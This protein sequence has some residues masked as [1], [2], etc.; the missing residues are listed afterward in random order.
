MKEKL[1]K[2]GKKLL[3]VLIIF[4]ILFVALIVSYQVRYN[5]KAKINDYTAEKKAESYSEEIQKLK[6]ENEDVALL[7]YGIETLVGDEAKSVNSSIEQVTLLENGNTQAI[8]NNANEKIKELT[9]GEIFYLEGDSS[10]PYQEAFFG[11]VVSNTENDGKTT[12]ITETPKVDEIFDMVDI[13]LSET[14]TED[15]LKNIKPMEGVNITYLGESTGSTVQKLDN[16]QEATV[17]NLTNLQFE[18][19]EIKQ[20]DQKSLSGKLTLEADLSEHLQSL[21]KYLRKSEISEEELKNIY[22]KING[23][24]NFEHVNFDTVFDWDFFGGIHD[25]QFNIDKK[26]T[27]SF[28]FETG[29]ET[30]FGGEE[31]ITKL[32]IA[33]ICGVKEKLIPLFY[34]D[35]GT[36][37]MFTVITNPTNLSGSIEDFKTSMPISLGIMVY[38]DFQGN[39][40]IGLSLDYSY[41]SETINEL[42]I[43]ENDEWKFENKEVYNEEKST[44]N[45]KGEIST[46]GDLNTG[47]DAMVNIGSANIIDLAILKVGVEADFIGSLSAG[48]EWTK[49]D[50]KLTHEEKFEGHARVYLKLLDLDI[51]FKLKNKILPLSI[52]EQLTLLDITLLELGELSPSHYNK[53]I[54][55]TGQVSAEDT[56][57]NYYKTSYGQLIKEDKTDKEKQT[58]YTKEFDQ[59]CAIDDSYIYVTVFSDDGGTDV[60]RIDKEKPLYKTVIENVSYVLTQDNNYIYYVAKDEEKKIYRYNRSNSEIDEF[61]SFD[62]EVQLMIEQDDGNFYITTLDDGLGLGFLGMADNYYYVVGK[63]KNIIHEYGS[64]PTVEQYYISDQGNYYVAQKFY[65]YGR[66]RPTATEN[67]FMS[68]D[69]AIQVPTETS[70]GWKNESF[71]IVTQTQL[72]DYSGYNLNVYGTPNGEMRTITTVKSK[73]AMFTLSESDSGD[74]Y[75]FDQEENDVVLYK[76]DANLTN[77]TEVK[78]FPNET[79]RCQME[80]CSMETTDNVLYFYQIDSNDT[81]VLYRYDMN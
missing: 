30:E 81:K 22:L 58:I 10:T 41:E 23:E 55:K 51:K 78:R 68:K 48:I 18:N 43:V 53:D 12:L 49:D 33:D 31:T 34:M 56:K 20:V 39:V 47:I 80:N 13:D 7:S 44:L 46:A 28:G 35:V 36:R 45:L 40:K 16:T 77:K 11:K 61:R 59:I 60:V 50:T 69:R 54:M 67:L 52:Q 64:E 65:A 38:V 3:I 2:I 17:D 62:N 76:L 19:A 29:V 73:Y 74:W 70:S 32:G 57:N 25:L 9:K 8:I 42:N 6:E 5:F 27:S 66:T 37:K 71:G 75:F 63:D 72:P 24:L 1:K 26:I 14:L 21:I 4:V 79:F 15:N